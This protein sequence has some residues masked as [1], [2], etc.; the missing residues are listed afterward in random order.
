[1]ALN[2]PPI[3]FFGYWSGQLPAV[4][5][6]HFRSFVRQHPDS[7]YELWLDEDDF[8][9]IRA[10]EL[11]WITTHPRIA[12]RPFSLNALIEK[13]VSAKPVAAYDTHPNLRKTASAVHRKLAP[14]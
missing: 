2:S 11:Q 12:V 3:T 1:M 4:T 9:S 14:Q 13:H 10:P 8:S 5:D 6:L 7:R